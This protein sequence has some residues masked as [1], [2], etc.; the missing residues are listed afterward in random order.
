MGERPTGGPRA[1][2]PPTPGS[3]MRAHEEVVLLPQLQCRCQ[4]RGQA[5]HRIGVALQRRTGEV[6]ALLVQ[7]PASASAGGWLA[8]RERWDS[9]S[10]RSGL[11]G[12]VRERGAVEYIYFWLEMG[13]QGFEAGGNNVAHAMPGETEQN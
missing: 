5:L 10:W 9:N 8:W 4:M 2:P 13:L 12:K 7:A 11:G 1:A 3:L 6:I